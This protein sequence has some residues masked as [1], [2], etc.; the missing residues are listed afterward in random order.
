M[1]KY[2]ILSNEEKYSIINNIIIE[3]SFLENGIYIEISDIEKE[4]LIVL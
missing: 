1:M 4:N 2:F 3:L